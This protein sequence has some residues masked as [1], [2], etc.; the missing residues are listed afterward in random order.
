MLLAPVSATTVWFLMTWTITW[1][2]HISFLLL[3]LS[4]F[5]GLGLQVQVH[6]L[7]VIPHGEPDIKKTLKTEFCWSFSIKNCL[8][9]KAIKWIGV[10]SKLIIIGTSGYWTRLN[11]VNT[12]SWQSWKYAN[13]KKRLWNR[14]NKLSWVSISPRTDQTSNCAGLIR[15]NWF[16]TITPL[17]KKG[18]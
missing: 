15:I 5:F 8:Q 14:T 2:S 6:V 3:S 13:K 11:N 4:S 9:R 12:L 10:I 1:I 7:L 17:L 18:N 16:K